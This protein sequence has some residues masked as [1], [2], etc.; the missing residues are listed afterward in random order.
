M[1]TKLLDIDKVWAYAIA[2]ILGFFE[3]LWVLILW[4]F[5]F[6][7]AD[8]I[9]G[10]YAALIEGKL[11]TS[12][13]MRR[14]VGKFISY[15]TAIILLHG[16]DSYMLPFEALYLARI[17]ATIICGIELHSIFE[18]LYRATGNEVFLILT[19]FTLHKLEKHT[20]V[21]ADEVA[22]HSKKSVRK[23]KANGKANNR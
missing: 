1:M 17:G 11:I 16:I 12:N 14:T 18:N 3:P 19:Q 2:S 9:T 15:A 21:K 13:K 6:I 8:F 10:I 20:G 7:M 4:F 23:G 22:K 5:I